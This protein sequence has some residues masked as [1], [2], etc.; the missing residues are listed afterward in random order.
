MIF[1]QKNSSPIEG[2]QGQIDAN[3]SHDISNEL[4]RIV[5]PTLVTVGENDM[6]LPPS[7]SRE[8]AD[9]INGAEL[10]IFPGGSHLFGVQDPA[11]FNRVT[12]EWLG[13]MRK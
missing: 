11:T 8:L 4:N 1:L 6:C 7:Y 10:V 3:Q 13:R 2:M 12:L 5:A 9:G